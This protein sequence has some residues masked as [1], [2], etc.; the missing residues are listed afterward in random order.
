MQS[1]VG[2][3]ALSLKLAAGPHAL[4]LQSAQ[5]DASALFAQ[6]GASTHTRW[7]FYKSFDQA[8]EKNELLTSL[9][10]VSRCALSLSLVL[11][12]NISFQPA[13]GILVLT[14]NISL[15]PPKKRTWMQKSR[16]LH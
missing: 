9:F 10:V 13:I 14:K 11:I 16:F 7:R 12:K 8:F 15:Q 2:L 1:T 4:S 3:A 6:L 5:I